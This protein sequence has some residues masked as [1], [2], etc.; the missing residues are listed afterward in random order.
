[1]TK[2]FVTSMRHEAGFA[3]SEVNFSAVSEWTFDPPLPVNENL[4][5]NDVILAEAIKAGSAYRG[6]D[7]GD[8]EPQEKEEDE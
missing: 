4:L 1:M 8:S 6:F 5:D 7:I 3:A 2:I